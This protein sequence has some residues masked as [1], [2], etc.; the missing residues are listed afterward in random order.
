[1]MTSHSVMI[2][3]LR[4]KI[5]K[6]D[7]FGDFLCV[8]EYDSETDVFSDVIYLFMLSTFIINVRLDPL[9]TRLADTKCPPVAQRKQAKRDSI[10]LNMISYLSL[11]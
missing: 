9:W 4:I 5:L 2:S 3:S 10:R 1:M 7:K 8:I 6:I 11:F